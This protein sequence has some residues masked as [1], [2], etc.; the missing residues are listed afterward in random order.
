MSGRGVVE[1]MRCRSL[2]ADMRR[3]VDAVD[4][5][6][7]GRPVIGDALRERLVALRSSCVRAIEQLEPAIAGLE[8]LLNELRS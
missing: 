8:E 1:L 4:A 2:R 7:D 6:L 5:L 3:Q